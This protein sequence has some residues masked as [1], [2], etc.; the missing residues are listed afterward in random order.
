MGFFGGVDGLE[1]F[2]TRCLYMTVGSVP[3]WWGVTL[4]LMKEEGWHFSFLLCFVLPPIAAYLG[5]RGKREIRA[6][7]AGAGLA[8]AVATLPL[9]FVL[10]SL[11]GA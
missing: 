10:A 4:F 7:L 3:A 2:L 1:L 5:V 6:G 11:E 8:L 9:M